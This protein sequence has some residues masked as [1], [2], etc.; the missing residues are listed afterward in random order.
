MLEL[1]R[2]DLKI[3]LNYCELLQLLCITRNYFELL[4]FFTIFSYWVI[5][6]STGLCEDYARDY[7]RL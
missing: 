7:V 3:T 2:R 6:F 5:D 1:L 4:G